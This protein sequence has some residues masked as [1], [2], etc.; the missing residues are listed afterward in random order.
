M[1]KKKTKHEPQT[2]AELMGIN[3]TKWEDEKWIHSRG[4]I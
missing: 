3:K 4:E 1:T 2:L